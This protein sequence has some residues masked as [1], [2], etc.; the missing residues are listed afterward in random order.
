MEIIFSWQLYSLILKDCLF[1]LFVYKKIQNQRSVSGKKTNKKICQQNLNMHIWIC[2]TKN[3]KGMGK[4]PLKIFFI[5]RISSLCN[6]FWFGYSKYGVYLLDLNKKTT[7]KSNVGEKI[8]YF[9]CAKLQTQLYVI[10]LL[11]INW[12]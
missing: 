12:N 3:P 2:C 6:D 11:R 1:Y 7:R 8:K 10:S 5:K 4:K 9:D